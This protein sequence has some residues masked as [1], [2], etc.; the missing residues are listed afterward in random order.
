MLR[1]QPGCVVGFFA[2][3]ADPLRGAQVAEVVLGSDHSDCMSWV[4]SFCLDVLRATA[5]S[6]VDFLFRSFFKVRAFQL[7]CLE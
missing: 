5:Q 4:G 3:S 7:S 1:I 6:I 2:A